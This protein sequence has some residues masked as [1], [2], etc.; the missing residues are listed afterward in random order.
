MTS[1]QGQINGGGGSTN[2]VTGQIEDQSAS[3]KRLGGSPLAKQG[4]TVGKG[5]NGGNG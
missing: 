3:F 5:D 4:T 1:G 2:I